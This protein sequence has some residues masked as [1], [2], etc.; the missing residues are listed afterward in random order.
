MEFNLKILNFRE[1][2]LKKAALW[3]DKTLKILKLYLGGGG[4][5]SWILA[6]WDLAPA[7]CEER[8]YLPKHEPK[9]RIIY[10]TNWTGFRFPKGVF[11]YD[12]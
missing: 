9:S 5:Y 4:S 8:V 1:M 2:I 6:S 10:V 11:H 3:R 12:H 7:K